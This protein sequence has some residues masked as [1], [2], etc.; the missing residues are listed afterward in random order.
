MKTIFT[1]VCILFITS[2]F[3]QKFECESK[4]AAYQ[5]LFKAKK[6]S[7]SF[8]IWNEVKK[9]C[10]KE[11]EI[12][13]T[14]GFNILQ[15]KI[16]NATTDQE[17]TSLVR[18]KMKLYDQY[19]KN[20][21]L[22]TADF[23]VNKAMILY[24]NKI[25]AKEEIFTLLNNGFLTA[26]KSI[27]HANAIYLYFSLCYEKY[28]EGNKDYTADLI[29]EK[30]SLVNSMLSQLQITYSQKI[31]EYKTAQRGINALVK[32]VATCDNLAAYYEKNFSS[33][34]DDSDWILSAL[35]N[36]SGKCSAKPIFATM[37]EKLYTTKATPK[38]AYFMALAST[39]Q[40][41]F[42]E[43]IRYYEE[44]AQLESNPLEKAN[45]YYTLATGLASGD[46]SKSKEYLN[47]ALTFDPKMG[48]AYLFLAQLYSS[49]NEECG[50]TDFEKK[51]LMFLAS[52]TATKA[53]V[54]DTKLKVTADKMAAD[55][56][57]KSLTQDEIKK[58][59]MNGKSFTINCWI[60]ETITF[61]S[62]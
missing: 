51:A 55:F 17:K 61:P 21:P 14:D 49:G 34:Q 25:N 31:Q 58:A 48:K 13:Y 12:V 54:A 52:Q 15:Y 7:E 6:L 3:A 37:A 8:E 10:P 41:K 53:G 59:K 38:S 35:N 33:N 29:I 28:K 56:T 50:K 44:S 60:N 20:F 39:K 40:R 62:K 16:D 46:K 19:N 18:D 45:I 57:T 43:A 22:T 11:S 23:E 27:T 4:T 26:S 1:F 2:S 24:D 42:T 9:N 36:L 47:K 30:Y 5:E 32:D